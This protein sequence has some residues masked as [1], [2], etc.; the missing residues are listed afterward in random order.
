MSLLAPPDPTMRFRLHPSRVS[1]PLAAVA[2]ALLLWH[3]LGDRARAAA[4]PAV[5]SFEAE[6]VSGAAVVSEGTLVLTGRE[7]KTWLLSDAASLLRGGR[8]PAGR[9]RPLPREPGGQV[10]LAG[11]SDAAWDGVN[12]LFVVTSHSR[13]PGGDAPPERYR[14]ARFRFDA[15]G[16]LLAARQSDALLRA[17]VQEV[18]FLAD[19]IRRT[20]ARTG[21]NIEGLAW[22]PRG[23]LLL[24]LR[25]PTITESTPRPHGAQEDAV[26]LRLR[27]PDAVFGD[28]PA[29]AA[30]GDT[31]KL[32]LRG[33]GIRGMA[34]DP[35][36][37]G[38]W[39]LSG[40]SAEPGHPVK[41]PWALWFW[42]G[43]GAPRPVKVPPGLDLEQPEAVT[44]LETP[45]GPR[46]L[47]VDP[48]TPD[49]RFALL[50]VPAPE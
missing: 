33:Q 48:G 14:L 49:S 19:A 6:H 4:A 39:L 24:G 21:L 11:V 42:S 3:P 7:G 28:P 13:T 29:D 38:A 1:T 18:P 15:T 37:K 9:L 5:G 23:E 22:D 31:V 2:A 46:L 30:L 40:L 35:Q 44:R 16:R 25:A 26:V 36:L 27:N 20:P 45:E 47:L 50:P 34:W 41:S 10:S 8:V 17:I 12:A 32:D 43:S